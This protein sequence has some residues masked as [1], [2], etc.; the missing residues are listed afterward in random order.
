RWTCPTC[1]QNCPCPSGLHTYPPVPSDVYGP[2]ADSTPAPWQPGMGQGRTPDDA[3]GAPSEP[4]AGQ[5]Q[6]PAPVTPSPQALASSGLPA[7][8]GAPRTGAAPVSNII[9]DFFGTGS[10]T[11]LLTVTYE[12]TARGVMLEQVPGGDPSGSFAFEVGEDTIPNDLFTNGPGTDQLS[13][14]PDAD[15]FP[16]AEPVEPT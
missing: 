6:P 10:S 14:S 2:P 3:T 11:S 1:Q 4:F 15:T 7:G 8:F 9:G 5:T 16:L 12:F 13:P